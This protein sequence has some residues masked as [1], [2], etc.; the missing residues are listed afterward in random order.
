MN[1]LYTMT[2]ITINVEQPD[3]VYISTLLVVGS[4]LECMVMQITQC[5][6]P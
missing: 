5:T 1:K 4:L 6:A 2:I 3:E